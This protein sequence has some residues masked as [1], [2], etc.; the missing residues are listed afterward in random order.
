MTTSKEEYIKTIEMHNGFVDEAENSLENRRDALNWWIE[1]ALLR[2][3]LTIDE[4]NEITVV[5]WEDLKDLVEHEKK[6]PR[7]FGLAR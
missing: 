4:V 2:E 3:I 1:D 7:H 6:H 5:R